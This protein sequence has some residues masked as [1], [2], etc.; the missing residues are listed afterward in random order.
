MELINQKL[1]ESG[2]EL[3][4]E[5]NALMESTSSELQVKID[6]I[7]DYKRYLDDGLKAVTERRKELQSLEK[8]VKGQ[9]ERFSDYVRNCMARV[10]L[11]KIESP[12]SRITIPKRRKI[13]VIT[14]EK[15]I[16]L[17]YLDHVPEQYIISKARIKAALEN[18]EKIEGAQLEDGKESIMIKTR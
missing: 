9:I 3:S 12:F 15:K 11:K 1:E 2:G 4:D 17:E 8:S 13:V 7:V 14:D 10:G 5:I 18:G 16:P 6:N